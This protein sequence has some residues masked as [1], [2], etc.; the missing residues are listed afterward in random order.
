MLEGCGGLMMRTGH[1]SV[2]ISSAERARVRMRP[3]N[4]YG[5]GDSVRKEEGSQHLPLPIPHQVGRHISISIWM[6]SAQ[7]WASY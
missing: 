5:N 3:E 6:N 7:T 2:H 1:P 4:G